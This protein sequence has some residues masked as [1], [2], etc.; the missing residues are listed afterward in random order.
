[1]SGYFCW[2]FKIKDGDKD[3]DNKLMFLCID[4]SKLLENYLD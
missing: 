2:S 4:D 3:K 1:M